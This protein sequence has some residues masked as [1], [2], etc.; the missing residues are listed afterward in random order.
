MLRLWMFAGALVFLQGCASVLHGDEQQVRVSVVCQGQ[1]L[2][3]ACS[4][5]NSKGLWHFTAPG[6][7][8]V[9]KDFSHLQMACKSPFFPEVTAVVPS[10]LNVSVAGNLWVGGLVGTGVDV[11]R[12]S[13]FAYNPDVRI[14]FPS[15]R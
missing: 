3:A 5:Q 1:V 15:C 7:I 12:G 14:H 8:R 4:A 10:K 13:A 2:P 6:T 11:Y 9:N